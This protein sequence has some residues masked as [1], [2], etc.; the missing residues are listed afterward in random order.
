MPYTTGQFALGLEGLALLRAGPFDTDEALAARVAELRD[1]ANALDQPEYAGEATGG[2]VALS[3]GYAMW[4]AS[5]DRSFNPL[6]E[7]EEPVVRE[8]VARWPSR[9]RVLDAACGTGR[10]TALLVEL[11]HTVC[12]ID[13]SLEMLAVARDKVPGARFLEGSMLPMPFE[14][15]EFDAALSA[16]ALSHFVD[17]AGPVAELTR[18]VRPG[19]RIVISDFHPYMVLLGGQAVF[20]TE[21][22]VPHFVASHAHLPGYM[23]SVFQEAGLRVTACV[24]PTWTQAAALGT[25][26]GMSATLF[27]EA[28][29]GIPL[30]I[31][32]VLTRD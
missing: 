6:L 31:V 26:P 32:W 14:D 18:V 19:G 15:G 25:F 28:I 22:G 16:L 10:H 3:R 2:E 17:P 9:S 12:G 24:E 5:Y 30:A 29:A 21:G 1:V 11:G 8:E 13:I 4:A 7:V 27:E 20:R 23:L